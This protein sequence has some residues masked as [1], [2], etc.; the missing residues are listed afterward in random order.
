MKNKDKLII[1]LSII[2]IILIIIIVGLLIKKGMPISS[3]NTLV[4]NAYAYVSNKDLEKCSGL[5]M[6]DDKKV[7]KKTLDNTTKVCIAYNLLD[8]DGEEVILDK[9]KKKTTCQI[10][11]GMVFALDNYEGD[12]C[13]VEKISKEKVEKKYKEIFGEKL[14]N[15]ESFTLDNVSVCHFYDG[16]Y[17]CGLS[18][19]YTYVFGA[20]P[21]TYRLIK[22]AYK[23]DD[24]LIIYDYFLKIINDECYTSFVANDKND[25]CTKKYDDKDG[26]T[27][28]FMKKSA[29]VYKHTFKENNGTYYWVSS[30]KN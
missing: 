21:H 18:E 12:K 24:K 2:I 7:T 30:E 15:N 3:N 13:T 26:V 20:E 16:Y 29:T 9:T 8:D 5:V 6:Y 11:K 22:S 19:E 14:K 23:K 10:K 28:G 1:V 4:K 17:Y 25:K 27:R